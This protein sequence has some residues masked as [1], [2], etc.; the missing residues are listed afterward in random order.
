[1]TALWSNWLRQPHA[2]ALP[3]GAGPLRLEWQAQPFDVAEQF[4]VARSESPPAV[5]DIRQFR[6]LLASDCGLDVGHAVIEA[7]G[8]I[9]LED[10]LRRAVP[11]GV[12]DAHAVLAK[13]PELLV[14]FGIRGRKHPAF[15][16]RDHLAGMEGEAS[17]PA[18]GLADSIP[19]AAV[20]ADLASDST[21]G[22][23]DQGN[24]VAICDRNERCEI[25][26]H[27][28]LV[29]HY[30]RARAGRDR[31]GHA[32]R[33]D[34]VGVRIDVDEDGGRT[35]ISNAIGGRDKGMAGRDHL[36]TRTNVECGQSKV[37]GGGAVGN[38]ARIGRANQSRKVTLESGDLRPCET[39]PEST[40]SRAASASSSPRSGSA[41][42]IT[43]RP[44]LAGGRPRAIRV[45]P[46]TISRDQRGPAQAV[47]WHGSRAAAPLSLSTPVGVAPD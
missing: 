11:H 31:F 12:R 35:A 29:D 45:R 42:G 15:A 18:V 39:Q 10:H 9:V 27:P 25:A 21:G 3:V 41:I 22:I 37:Q 26:G 1:M 43:R 2:I 20:H 46:A 33:I 19:A 34:V 44:P 14:E 7:D 23:L 16:R 4:R 40:A 36:V 8:K 47:R 6:Q 32:V 24:A 30:D 17:D 28:H 13:Q 38:R 5:H